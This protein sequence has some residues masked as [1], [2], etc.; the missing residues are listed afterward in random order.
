MYL[1]KKGVTSYIGNRLIFYSLFVAT[2][3]NVVTRTTTC[4]L[5]GS[6]RVGGLLIM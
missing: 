4:W 2:D 5:S 1:D 6:G 3:K